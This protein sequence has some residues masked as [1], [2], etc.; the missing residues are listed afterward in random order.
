MHGHC[1][2]LRN[3]ARMGDFASA[4]PDC[5]SNHTGG[6]GG[7]VSVMFIRLYQRRRPHLPIVSQDTFLHHSHFLCAFNSERRKSQISG[8]RES[9]DASAVFFKNNLNGRKHSS[10]A[11][12]PLFSAQHPVPFS[13][14][15]HIQKIRT[16]I[17]RASLK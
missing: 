17:C 8:F 16:F 2:F 5:A 14:L 9:A 4:G 11:V 15:Q 13:C 12:W 7:P 6:L 10:E 1:I 3:E